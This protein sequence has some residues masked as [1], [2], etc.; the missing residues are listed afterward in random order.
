MNFTNVSLT[1]RETTVMPYSNNFE[2]VI[3]A[4]RI[5]SMITSILNIIILSNRKLNDSTY[6]FLMVISI[7]EF[8]YAGFLLLYSLL[9]TLCGDEACNPVAY[10]FYLLFFIIISEYVTSC[11]PFFNILMEGFLTIKRIIII[12]KKTHLKKCINSKHL[13]FGILLLS[14]LIHTPNIFMYRITPI[15]RD[16]HNATQ[17]FYKMDKTWFGQT[18]IAKIILIS[19]TLIRLFLSTIGLFIMNIITLNKF[20]QYMNRKTLLI[21]LKSIFLPFF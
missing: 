12:S 2:P 6:K 20:T 14:F 19:V 1:T 21:A 4:L 9:Y 7:S 3:K 18:K 17:T 15:R 11:L 13:V 10:Y 5:I 16:F 8:F